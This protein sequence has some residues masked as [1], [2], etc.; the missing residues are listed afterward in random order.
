M[1]SKYHVYGYFQEAVSNEWIRRGR[2]QGTT[3]SHEEN[4]DRK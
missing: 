3:R 4:L 2:G 1:L